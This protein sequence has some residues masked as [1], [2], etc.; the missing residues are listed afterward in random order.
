MELDLQ[1]ELD[2][3]EAAKENLNKKILSYFEGK[4]VLG[5]D[6]RRFFRNENAFA[7]TKNGDY[8][9]FKVESA[10]L[11]SV[12]LASD[13]LAK[14]IVLSGKDSR[15]ALRTLTIEKDHKNTKQPFNYEIDLFETE[16]E[17][18]LFA[19]LKDQTEPRRF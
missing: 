13:E 16:E 5:R 2:A 10:R 4:W 18:I 17:A 7:K 12:K 3:I 1:N 14:E 6:N 11:K 8:I 15:G 19:T 9:C